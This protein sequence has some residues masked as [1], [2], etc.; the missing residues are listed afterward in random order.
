MPA[1]KSAAKRMLTSDKARIRHKARRSSMKTSE[2][3]F[4]SF[5]ESSEMD[6]AKEQLHDIFKQ[7]D[8]AVK[9]GTIPKNKRNRKKSRLTLL[10][11]KSVV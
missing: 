4:Q 7:L 6:K 5:L 10:L 3:K 8:K 11:N 9:S 1:K 2:K